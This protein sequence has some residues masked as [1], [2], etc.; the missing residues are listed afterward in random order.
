MKYIAIV[1]DMFLFDFERKGTDTLTLIVGDKKGNNK[2]V[3]LKP[4]IKPTLTLEDGQSF[5]ITEEHIQAMREYEEMA[6]IK[7]TLDEMGGK[8]GES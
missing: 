3:R 5:Y 7:K 6:M 8:L 2:K 1:D 4:V